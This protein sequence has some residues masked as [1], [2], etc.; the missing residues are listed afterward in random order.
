MSVSDLSAVEQLTAELFFN[1]SV[2]AAFARED[3]NARFA[4]AFQRKDMVGYKGAST[5]DAVE[6]RVYQSDVAGG[7]TVLETNPKNSP[8]LSR[9]IMKGGRAQAVIDAVVEG[10]ASAEYFSAEH[11]GAL[12][13][14]KGQIVP[15]GAG[16]QLYRLNINEDLNED[17][18]VA[19]VFSWHAASVS[20]ITLECLAWPFDKKLDVKV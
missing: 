10:F 5:M 2:Q 3:P 17:H 8:A 20:D 14:A 12:P 6:N 11:L 19:V 9:V 18:A 15:E 16:N 4:A 13:A 7:A 1:V